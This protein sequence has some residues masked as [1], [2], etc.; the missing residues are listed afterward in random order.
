M[1][2]GVRAGCADC[3]IPK[4]LVGA[5]Y[6]HIVKGIKDLWAQVRFDY[7]D[8]KVWEAQRGRLADAV[9]DGLR[10]NESVTC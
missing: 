9:R 1:A 7:E 10:A 6:T 2:K 4:G 8:P 5:T 3:H